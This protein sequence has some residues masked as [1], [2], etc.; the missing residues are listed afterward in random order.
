[1]HMAALQR[2]AEIL[3]GRQALAQYLDV[4]LQFLELWLDGHTPPPPDVFLR[5]I[6]VV[7]EHGV[8]EMRNGPLAAPPPPA[9]SL[10]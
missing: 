9:D 6:D 10:N 4:P 3:G 1:V 8:V 5:A 7:V 2:A